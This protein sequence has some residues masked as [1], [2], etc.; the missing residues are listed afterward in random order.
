M[1]RENAKRCRFTKRLK[2]NGNRFAE[3]RAVSSAQPQGFSYEPVLNINITLNDYL[4]KGEVWAFFFFFG[5]FL[6]LFL[7]SLFA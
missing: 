6:F 5:L 2:Q 1:W 4:V 7:L 3:A